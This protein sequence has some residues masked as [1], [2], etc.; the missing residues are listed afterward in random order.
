MVGA[1]HTRRSAA[2]EDVGVVTLY[3]LVAFNAMYSPQAILLEGFQLPL[4]LAAPSHPHSPAAEPPR[5]WVAPVVDLVTPEAK[6][7]INDRRLG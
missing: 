1:T 7:S 3:F 4:K 6:H 5:V 2:G